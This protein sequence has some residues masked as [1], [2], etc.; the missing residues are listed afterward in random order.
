MNLLVYV[1]ENHL[2]L[3]LSYRDVLN[4]SVAE[5]AVWMEVS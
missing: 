2:I 1:R 3:S 4:T 5:A